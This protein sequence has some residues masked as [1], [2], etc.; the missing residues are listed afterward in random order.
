MLVRRI[1]RPLLAAIFVSG[2]VAAL[3]AP[4]PHAQVADPVAPKAARSLPAPLPEDPE[5]LVKIDA[6]VKVVA[7][8]ALATGHLPRLAALALA[9]SLV[10]TTLAAHRFW[11]EED[12]E[13]RLQQQLHFTKNLSL[14]GGLLLAAVDTGGKPSVGWRARRAAAGVGE[15]VSGNPVAGARKSL[16]SV[17]R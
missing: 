3:K 6:G 4:G 1:A 8:L 2:G 13:A 9:G 14:L 16:A 10:P 12:E 5:T 7:G 15:T 17:G 11:E